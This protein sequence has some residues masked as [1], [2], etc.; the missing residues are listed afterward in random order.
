MTHLKTGSQLRIFYVGIILLVA[1]VVY[2]V[3]NTN[4]QAYIACKRVKS[5]QDY[6]IITVDRSIKTLPSIAYYKNP[7]HKA[8]LKKQLQILKDYRDGFPPVACS[9]NIFLP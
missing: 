3:Y 8:E 6:A 1:L 9:K 4:H 5:L 7:D 2:G